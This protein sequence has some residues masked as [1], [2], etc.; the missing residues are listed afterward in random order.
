MRRAR[1][2]H[3]VTEVRPI[4]LCLLTW[5]YLQAK[6]RLADLGA[7]LSDGAPQLH[8]A[9]GIT[10]IANHLVN[11]RGAQSRMLVQGLADELGVGIDNGCT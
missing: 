2:D 7:Q 1:P 9:T 6:E 4:G 5:K 3:H 10:P 11:A 8:D